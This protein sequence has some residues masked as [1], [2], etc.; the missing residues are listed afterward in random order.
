MFRGTTPTLLLELNTTVSLANL[1]E[2]WV[3]FKDPTTEIN[4]S[5]QDVAV[6]D[7]E[8]TVTVHLS[9]EDTLRLH[10][11]SCQVQVRFKTREGFAYASDIYDL[12]VGRIL[13]EGVI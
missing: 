12:D 8:K 6:D 3:T 1:A 5:L 2:L 9:Q 4:K 10:N 7:E 13:K 11:R